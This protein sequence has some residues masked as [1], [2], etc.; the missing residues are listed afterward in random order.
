MVLF[1][2]R[3]PAWAARETVPAEKKII[4]FPQNEFFLPLNFFPAEGIF[5]TVGYYVQKV[6]PTGKQRFFRVAGRF[7][8]TVLVL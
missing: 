2:V 8:A 5:F 3:V 6:I 4:V 1:A 7:S